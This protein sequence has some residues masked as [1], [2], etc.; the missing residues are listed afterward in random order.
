MD[1]VEKLV[2]KIEAAV[3][4]ADNIGAP[5]PGAGWAAFPSRSEIEHMPLSPHPQMPGKIV[6]EY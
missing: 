6:Q 1:R 2:E 5:A 3:N 4:V